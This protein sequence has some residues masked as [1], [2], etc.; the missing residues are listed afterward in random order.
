[1]KPAGLHHQRTGA[2]AHSFQAEENSQTY[3]AAC[4]RDADL[5]WL[6]LQ[7]PVSP[8]KIPSSSKGCATTQSLSCPESGLD[9]LTSATWQAHTPLRS[10]TAMVGHILVLSPPFQAHLGVPFSHTVCNFKHILKSRPVLNR[11]AFV[12]KD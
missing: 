7:L 8:S 4:K 5:C 6:A 3:R 1:M 12:S 2:G 10:T 11:E 9:T